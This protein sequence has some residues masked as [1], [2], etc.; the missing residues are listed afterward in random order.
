M[1][2]DFRL[3]GRGIFADAA[4]NIADR[5]RPPEEDLQQVD[6]A[7]PTHKFD[8]QPENVDLSASRLKEAAVQNTGV[9]PEAVKPSDAPSTSEATTAA[10]KERSTTPVKKTFASRFKS[11]SQRVPDEHKERAKA[12]LENGKQYFREQFPKE[13]RDQFV[14][15]LKKVVV[16]CQSHPSYQQSLSWFLTQLEKYFGHGKRVASA[17]AGQTASFFDDPLLNQAASEMRIF[18]ERCAHGQSMQGMFD[19]A[20]RMWEDA[21]NDDELRAW[22]SRVDTFVRKA[23]ISS[24]PI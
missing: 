22:W 19:A 24:V 7:T 13:R 8:E 15:R 2:S 4:Q 6:E 5:A 21:Q 12:E 11:V 14:Y 10:A 1:L 9:S 20:Q 3:I 17:G 23:S 18:L 16:E